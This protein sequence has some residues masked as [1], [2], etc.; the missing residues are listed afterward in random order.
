MA[1]SALPFLSTLSLRR[2]T[3]RHRASPR[4]EKNFYPRSP[5]GERLILP[6]TAVVCNLF[7][8]TLSLRR[9]TWADTDYNLSD[10]ISIHALLAESDVSGGVLSSYFGNFYPRS[11]CGERRA[12]IDGAAAILGF[13]STLS[14]RRATNINSSVTTAD[15]ISIH[16]LLAESDVKQKITV[17]AIA[18]SIHALLA[19]SDGILLTLIIGFSEFL[20]TLSLRRATGVISPIFLLC[21]NLYP[22]SPCGERPLCQKASVPFGFNFYPRSPCG[23][24]PTQDA[25]PVCPGL[26]SIH[27]LLAES[28]PKCKKIIKQQKNFY[29]RSPCGERPLMWYQCNTVVK[30]SIHALLAESDQ[31]SRR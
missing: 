29:P 27:A 21:C 6:R 20:S 3:V 5:C 7:L 30:I 8:S 28:D 24:R 15:K 26:I 17:L 22:R 1:V 14:L 23:E 9:A 4:F 16:A 13:L 2:A 31:F 11:P 10:I 19:E 12:D 18:I 25:A